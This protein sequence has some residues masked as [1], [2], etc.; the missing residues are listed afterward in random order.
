MK[1]IVRSEC[2]DSTFYRVLFE[3]A[4][5]VGTG[6]LLNLLYDLVSLKNLS[7]EKEIIFEGKHRSL[8]LISRNKK[9]VD[10]L[11]KHKK[12]LEAKNLTDQNIISVV[13]ELVDNPSLLDTYLENARLLEK[14]KIEKIK[15]VSKK[16]EDI[17]HININQEIY[18]NKSNKIIAIRKYY[19]DGEIECIR[20]EEGYDYKEMNCALKGEV[21][22]SWIL[23]TENHENGM[24]FR[25]IYI[26]GFDFN[27]EKLPTEEE[28]Q[29][30]ELPSSLK[31]KL[32]K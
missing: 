22:T 10:Y 12:E 23:H 21:S 18:Y 4:K 31:L 24:Q 7:L 9:V 29:S 27:P 20:V 6:E 11:R 15:I 13:N 5:E 25:S 16:Y 28:L 17:F 1:I 8:S 3:L 32:T 14:Y 19:T 26:T 30:Y 2:M